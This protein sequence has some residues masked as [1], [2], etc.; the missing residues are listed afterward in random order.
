[1]KLQHYLL[2]LNID[3]E[4][5]LNCASTGCFIKYLIILTLILAYR[6]RLLYPFV[7]FLACRHWL[8]SLFV[9]SLACR[10]QFLSL[11]VFSL[12]CRHQSLSPFFLLLCFLWLVD[13]V[14]FSCCVFFEL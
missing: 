13:S 3:A 7:V 14:S 5:E 11:V 1:M 10:Y 6:H 2:L 4:K 12:S 8:L 9:F